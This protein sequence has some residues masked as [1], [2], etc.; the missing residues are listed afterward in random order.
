MR[1]IAFNGLLILLAV[2]CGGSS[3]PPSAPTS[4]A[5]NPSTIAGAPSSA[6]SANYTQFGTAIAAG[7]WATSATWS[8]YNGKNLAFYF[9]KSTANNCQTYLT[10]FRICNQG[11]SY[12][13]D[14]NNY[15]NNWPTGTSISHPF[16]T[17]LAAIQAKMM[18][19]LNNPL[20]VT[21]NQPGPSQLGAS[22]WAIPTAEGIY[23]L[24][25][26]YPLIANPVGFSKSD[27]TGYNLSHIQ[28]Y[29]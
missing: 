19:I 27:G 16:G 28:T 18:W 5:F 6:V 24:D 8:Q 25:N 20:P 22:T 17:T 7:T 11:G 4:T 21:P 10:V 15:Q 29:Q 9:T 3:S 13:A 12:V 2:S 14:H 23:Y 1:R 26:S